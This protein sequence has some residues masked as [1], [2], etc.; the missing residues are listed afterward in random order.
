[1][2]L[3][4]T[5]AQAG[6]QPTSSTKQYCFKSSHEDYQDDPKTKAST[7]RDHTNFSAC[8]DGSSELLPNTSHGLVEEGTNSSEAAENT[9]QALTISAPLNPGSSTLHIPPEIVQPQIRVVTEGRKDLEQNENR[10][11]EVNASDNH[12]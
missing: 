9:K 7:R 1:M 11:Q 5:T 3:P 2:E 12:I 4:D 8:E 6:E 10:I